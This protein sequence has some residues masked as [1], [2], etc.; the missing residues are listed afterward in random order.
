MENVYPPRENRSWGIL[1]QFY[2]CRFGQRESYN[3]YALI[4]TPVFMPFV[5]SLDRQ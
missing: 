4:T 2:F 5:E 1:T 3:S